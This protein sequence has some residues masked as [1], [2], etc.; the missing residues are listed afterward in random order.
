LPE[1]FEIFPNCYFDLIL[2]NHVLEHIPG[3]YRRH[4][5]AFLRI[6]R[7]G[8][9]MVFTIPPV[10]MNRSTIQDGENLPSDEDRIRM[11][12]QK[13]HYKTFGKDFVEWFQERSDGSFWAMSIPDDVRA[14]NSAHDGFVWVFEKHMND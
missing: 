11:H 7:P 9:H 14:I 10:Y 5:D 8:G 6:L 2:H 13:D 1:G 4:L 12:G 3:D